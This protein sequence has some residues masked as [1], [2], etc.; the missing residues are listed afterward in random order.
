MER[1]LPEKGRDSE[2]LM[3]ARLAALLRWMLYYLAGIPLMAAAGYLV[4]GLRTTGRDNL[5]GIRNAILISNHVHHLDSGMIACA[6]FPRRLN[7]VSHIGNF[8]LPIWG[9]FLRP[10][11][12]IPN[13]E[14]FSLQKEFL[15]MS[16]ERLGQGG[17]VVIYPEGDIRLYSKTVRKFLP[18]AFLLSAETM[19]PVIPI[20]FTQRASAGIRRLW[21]RKPLFS[22]RIGPPIYPAAEGSLKERAAEL[23]KRAEDYF[24]DELK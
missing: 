2:R 18:G 8:S 7:F 14:T 23:K 24:A 3:T 19:S 22:V 5:K 16:A 9:R 1:R 13:G 20:V 12:C 11:G 21:H 4:L 10:L 6:V 17:T 15:R